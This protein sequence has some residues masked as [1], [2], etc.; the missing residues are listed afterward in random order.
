V[1][2]FSQDLAVHVV[3]VLVVERWQT[4]QHL[5]QKYTK[6]PPIDR[7]CIASASQQFR[8]KVFWCSTERYYDL[9]SASGVSWGFLLTVGAVLILHVQLAKTEIA[10]CNMSGVIEENVLWLEITVDN[11]ETV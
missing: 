3:G 6:C 1:Q 11:V 5:V 8:R 2:W 9:V 7:L 4:R 10:E